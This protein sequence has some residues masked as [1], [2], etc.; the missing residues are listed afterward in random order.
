LRNSDVR[1]VAFTSTG[2]I[3]YSDSHNL[4]PSGASPFPLPYNG[5]NYIIQRL[6]RKIESGSGDTASGSITNARAR[7]IDPT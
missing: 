1:T 2:D 4:T 6:S 7:V 3:T 5:Q